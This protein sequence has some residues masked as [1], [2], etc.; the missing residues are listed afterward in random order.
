MAQAENEGNQNFSY[1]LI[2]TVSLVC[3][4]Y[5]LASQIQW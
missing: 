3:I 5:V 1:S 4:C 2:W